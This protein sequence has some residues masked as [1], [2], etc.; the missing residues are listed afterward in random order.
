[1]KRALF[2]SVLMVATLA[3]GIGHADDWR[4][5]LY[6][7][8]GAGLNYSADQDY[9][10][11]LN[12]R[13]TDPEDGYNLSAAMGYDYGMLRS[14]IELGYRR[15]NVETHKLNGAVL[16]TPDG[17]GTSVS[18]M[19]NG[20][21]DIPTGTVITPYVGA[22][23]GFARVDAKGYG[24]AGTDFLDDGDTSFAYQ[25]MTGLDFAFDDALSV[26]AEY[27]YFVVDNVNMRTIAG[28]NS[29]LDYT[30]HTVGVGLRYNF[31]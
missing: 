18:A 26:Y 8:G 30:N 3:S 6:I 28:N 1:M 16:A 7:R 9:D 17:K 21:V 15:N 10:D 13:K 27:K 4:K 31:R 25:A 19:V 5:G 12:R 24:S 2:L 22:G 20:Y 23:I 14:E 29:D 11:G